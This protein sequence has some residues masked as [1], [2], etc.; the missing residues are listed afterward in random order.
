MTEAP[1][2]IIKFEK[3]SNQ[4]KKYSIEIK[5]LKEY[6][7]INIISEGEIPC[8]SFEKKIYLS[9]VKNNRYLSICTNISEIFISLEFQLKN[10]KDVKLIEEGNNLN[11]IIPLPSPLVKEVIFSIPQIQKDINLELKELYKIINQQQKTINKLNERITILEEKEKEESQYFISKNSNIIPNDREKDLAIRKWIDSNKK[12]FKFKLLFRMSR[13][14]NQSS[15][16]H[17]LCD[18]KEN[19]LT[20]IE[21]DNNLKFGGFASQSWGIP[22]QNIDKTFLFSLNQM[23]KFE[24]L[25]YN[26]SMHNGKNY[27]PI[28]GNACDIYINNLMTSGCEQYSDNSTFFNK[29]ELTNGNFKVKEIEVFQIS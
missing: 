21:T 4:N 29:Y 27:G 10:I 26:K 14:G 23:K 20:I 15:N 7:D 6:L 3:E 25:N 13:D 18:N 22:N 2:K 5:E 1:T 24:R 8:I 17:Q 9:D 11:L 19:L 16:Y 12:D 28:F